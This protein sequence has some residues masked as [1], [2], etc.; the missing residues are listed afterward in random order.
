VVGSGSSWEEWETGSGTE[1]L[2]SKLLIIFFGH[3]WDM[4]RCLKLWIE[5][6]WVTFCVMRFSILEAGILCAS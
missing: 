5:R 3:L 4:S 6:V 1:Q 2:P